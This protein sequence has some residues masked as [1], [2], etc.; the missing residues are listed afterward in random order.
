MTAG[1]FSRARLGWLAVL[2]GL[3]LAL[4]LQVAA[5]AGVPLYDGVVVQEP[6]RFLRPTGGQPGEPTSFEAAPTITGGITPAIVAATS[7]SPPQAQLIAQRD[8]FRVSA[9]AKSLHVTVTPI[10]QPA[11]PVEGSILGNVYRFSVT[12]DSG[13]TV[14]LKECKGCISVVL[15]APDAAGTAAIQRL[16]GGTWTAVATVPAG[17]L[18]TYSTN[19]TALGDFAVVGGGASAPGGSPDVSLIMIGLGL[20]FLGIIVVGLLFLRGQASGAN[21]DPARRAAPVGLGIEPRGRRLPS[22]RRRAR[23]PSDGSGR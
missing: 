11:L 7:E 4:T 10:E 5:P 14:P 1:V 17:I 23:R 8:A 2:A 20:A 19:P 22:K 3:G 18:A 21:P 15:R 9:G 12:D 13:A 6:Y 16:S